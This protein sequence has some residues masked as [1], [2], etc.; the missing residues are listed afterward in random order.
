MTFIFHVQEFIQLLTLC[1]V[2]N[3]LFNITLSN[4][5]FD[6]LPRQDVWK[7]N[8]ALSYRKVPSVCTVDMTL[9]LKDGEA[10]G[11]CW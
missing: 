11:L 9:E 3:P 1:E 10:R 5:K 8:M 7:F 2:I 6:T 4:I